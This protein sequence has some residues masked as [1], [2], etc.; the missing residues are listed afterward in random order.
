MTRRVASGVG[1][2]G[3]RGAARQ[4]AAPKLSEDA[5]RAAASAWAAAIQKRIARH[6]AYPRGTTRE[7]RVRVAMVILP[8]GQLDRVSV[9]R[10]S[11]TA[12][13]DEAALA[14]VKR[15]APFPPAPKALDD[16]WFDVG[17]WISFE[18]R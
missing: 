3:I 17:Q 12:E 10:S 7:G 1:D 13:L 9:V 18:R 8:S 6:Y 5:R 14:A 16:K 11:G 2:G 4:E 15:A